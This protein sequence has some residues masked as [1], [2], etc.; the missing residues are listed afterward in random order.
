MILLTNCYHHHHG[1]P[2]ALWTG[3]IFPLQWL[4]EK[5]LC[6]WVEGGD[7][8][9]QLTECNQTISCFTVFTCQ[10]V[11]ASKIIQKI[12]LSTRVSVPVGPYSWLT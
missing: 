5:C 1:H 10:N 8:L 12:I 7:I 4:T 2:A 3:G 6:L 11:S 9:H